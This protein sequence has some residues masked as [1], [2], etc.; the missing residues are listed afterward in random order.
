MLRSTAQIRFSEL[1]MDP[2]TRR[3]EFFKKVKNFDQLGSL[4]KKK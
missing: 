1:Y 4:W 2:S 3:N